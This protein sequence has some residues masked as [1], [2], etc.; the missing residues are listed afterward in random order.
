MADSTVIKPHGAE[1]LK[2]LLLIGK[3][4]EEELKKAEKLPK[5]IMSSRETGDL[6]MMGIGGFTPLEGYMGHDDWKGVCQDMKMTDG[7]FWP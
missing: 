4:K 1:E 2:I 7:T 5:V 3:E 6:I